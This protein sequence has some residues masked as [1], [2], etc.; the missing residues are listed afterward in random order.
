MDVAIP[1][2]ITAELLTRWNEPHRH[3][4]T[5]RHLD[6][7]LA[8]LGLLRESGVEFDERPVVLAAWF[9][10]A[11]YEPFSGTNE[12][13]SAALA[14]TL[15]AGDPDRDEVARLVELTKTHEPAADDR[16]GVAL[17]DADFA[18]L[19]ADAARYD[20]YAA[21]IGT[22]FGQVPEEIFRTKRRE[23][24]TDFLH[25]PTIFVSEPA[26]ERWES[27]ARANIAREID[28]LR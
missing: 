22:E 23:L 4:H 16:N 27:A 8:A 7:V 26:H 24:L 10:D 13:D 5:Q 18:V 9:H 17:S 6:E 20:E 21:N 3:H 14:R 28:E 2:A 19:G 1:N 12:E 25:R 15:L 11:I